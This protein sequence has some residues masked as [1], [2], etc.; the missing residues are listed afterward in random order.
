[1]PHPH[2]AQRSASLSGGRRIG[3]SAFLPDARILL[4]IREMSRYL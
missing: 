1:M 3:S 2:R 4:L